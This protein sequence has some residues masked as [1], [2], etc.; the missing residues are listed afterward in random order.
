VAQQPAKPPYLYRIVRKNKRKPPVIYWRSAPP[1]L[2][3]ELKISEFL[4]DEIIAWAKERNRRSLK[5]VTPAVAGTFQHLADLY[6][7]VPVF[8]VKPSKT[9]KKADPWRYGAGETVIEASQQWRD[10]A[11]RSRR[12]YTRIV[13]NIVARFGKDQVVDFDEEIAVELRDGMRET[14]RMANY[15]VNVL[16]AMI[17]VALERKSQFGVT[18]N[19]VANIRRLGTK[20]GVKPRQDYWTYD[21]ELSFVTDAEKS[22]PIIA[23]AEFLLAFTGQ[24]PGDCRRMTDQD[25]DGEKI[26]VVQSKTGARVWIPCHPKLKARLE[27]NIADARAQGILHFH[28]IR[29]SR[30]KAIGERYMAT[31]WDE[32]AARVKVAHLHRQDLR[33]TAVIRLAEAGCTIPE[34]ISITGHSPETANSI[35]NTYLVTTYEM[36]RNAIAKLEDHQAKRTKDG[37]S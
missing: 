18:H 16:S 28:F 24:R 32:I 8:G 2:E 30:G 15:V 1:G 34:I 19:P 11:E 9:Q 36:A 25:Y 37:Q 23:D 6:R 29:G 4:T 20:A 22:D 7:G 35:L 33:R 10:L 17:A 12:D 14:P 26:R 3:P 31:R 5:T 13:D 27:R 21:A